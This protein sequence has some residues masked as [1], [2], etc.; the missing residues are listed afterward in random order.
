MLINNIYIYI[1]SIYTNTV[2]INNI[3]IHVYAHTVITTWI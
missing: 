3:Y 1:Y 2:Y